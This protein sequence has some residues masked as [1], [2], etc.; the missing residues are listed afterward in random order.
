M[1]PESGIAEPEEKFIARQR[2]DKEV[3]AEMSTQA[4]IEALPFLCTGEVNRGI[5]R[6]L[7]AEAVQMK[8][9]L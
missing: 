9:S 7:P 5:V 1:T 3:P 6:K 8:V 2:H 4:A